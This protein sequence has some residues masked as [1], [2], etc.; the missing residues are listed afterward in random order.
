LSKAHTTRT[1]RLAGS[2][3]P[4]L[5][6]HALNPV[7]WHPW[8]P[9][10]FARAESEDKPVFLSIG[11]STC[12]W[13]HVME[14]ESFSDPEIA[15]LMND[16]FVCVKV[17]R[18]ERP[19]L[20]HL[21]MTVCQLLTGSG[22]WPLTI[23]MTPDKKPFFAGTYFPRDDR[24]GRPGMLQIIPRIRGLWF[25]EREALNS[26]S[27]EITE[28]LQAFLAPDQ[29]ASPSSS[30]VE[31]AYASLMEQYDE[32]HGGFGSAPKFPV[33]SNLLFLLKY[34]H[35][36]GEERALSM[37]RHTLRAMR[38]GGIYDHLG[39]GFHRYSTDERWFA[40]HFEKMLYDQALA[41][42]TC[43]DT[44]RATGEEEFRDMAEEIL[45]YVLRDLTSPEGGFYSA[46]DADSEGEEGKFYTWT[47]SELSRTLDDEEMRIVREIYNATDA[48]NYLGN[49][50]APT[51]QN[52]LFLRAGD[53]IPGHPG[54]HYHNPDSV[55]ARIREKLLSARS[56][57]PRPLR[58]EKILTDWN[59]LMIAALASAAGAL[60]HHGYADAA[61]RAF[62]FVR[63]NL[64]DENG[65]MLHLRY[66]DKIRIPAFLDDY[67]YML[68]GSLELHQLSLST[69]YLESALQLAAEMVDLFWDD[70]NGGFFF[71]RKG[72][73]LSAP[74][75]KPSF[76][77]PM[78]SGN[79]VAAMSLLRLGRLTA[80]QD[81]EEKGLGTLGAFASEMAGNPSGFTHMINALDTAHNGTAE[82]IIAGNPDSGD[83]KRLIQSLQ[84]SFLP[85]VT[86]LAFDP[87]NPNRGA[88]KNL[89]FVSNIKISDG[90]AAAYVCRNSAC[91]PPITDAEEMLKALSHRK[92]PGP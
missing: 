84:R 42:K 40:P 73:D 70:E 15:A 23:V 81:L 43:A 54:M 89:P 17:D 2:G 82:V 5:L 8:S 1:N 27:E 47:V 85:A 68:W 41:V 29:A 38:M 18:E 44:F 51:G 35:R 92:V 21:Y 58:D 48:G 3:S 46:E 25:N 59:G 30:L 67:A 11:Y 26:S 71:T 16:T 7:D 65:T 78:P 91:Q 79:S 52:I 39:Y 12:H 9:E 37:V 57:R 19:D 24:Y 64:V 77:G 61:K 55:H 20:D 69:D 28:G 50:G 76:D 90:K 32:R 22:G 80:R 14:E 86:T 4:Y 31:S 53:N 63:K 66:N 75:L 13:C 72:G 74:R 62:T 36:K 6:Q 10:A 88:W 83:T 87:D 60:G 49:A 33:F 45:A 56:A 34:W